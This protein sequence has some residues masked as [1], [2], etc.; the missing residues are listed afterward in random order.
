MAKDTKLIHVSVVD[1]EPQQI[2]KLRDRHQE[3]KESLDFETEF[4]VTN[5][6]ISWRDAKWL[7]EEIYNLMKREKIEKQEE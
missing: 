7:V 1:G 6:K 2:S 4:I 3:L 5:D